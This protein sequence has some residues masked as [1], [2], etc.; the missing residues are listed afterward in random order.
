MEKKKYP[1]MGILSA[2]VKEGAQTIKMQGWC[3]LKY[4]GSKEKLD[5]DFLSIDVPVQKK[6]G[7]ISFGSRYGVPVGKRFRLNHFVLTFD[8][9]QAL[10]YDIQNKVELVYK[11]QYKGRILYRPTDLKKG[12]NRRSE[13]FIR[14]NSIIYFRQSSKNSLYLTT[15]EANIYDYPEGEERIDKAYRK[16]KGCR[17]D[18]IMMYEKNCSRYEESASVLYEKLIDAGYDNVYYVVNGD[19]KEIQGLDEKYKKNL[20]EKDS[21]DHLELFFASNTFISTETTDHALQLRSTNKKVIEKQNG[22]NLKYVFLQHGVMYMVS[23]NSDKRV[24]FRD[25]NLGLQRTVVSSELEAKHF[26]ELAGMPREKLYITGLAKF[27]TSYRNDDADKIIIMPTWRRWEMNQAKEDL[28]GTGYFR[29]IKKMYDAVPEKLKEKVIVLPH[30]LMAEKFAG[31]EDFGKNLVLG[32]SYDKILRSCDML[33]TDYSSVSYDAFYRGANIVFYWAEKEECMEQYG[34]GS[35]LMLNNENVFGEV[36]MN[37]EDIRHAIQIGYKN[38]QP[39]IYIERYRKIV[40][41][42]DGHNADRILECLIKD[43]II[44]PKDSETYEA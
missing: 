8:I 11:D 38:K 3:I 29:M 27:D 34:E 21:D 40:E 6:A 16:A 9:D 31:E 20:V 13:V 23:L 2:K 41:F 5:T 24:G 18:L 22:K 17:Q 33:I 26:I 30:P 19:N 12:K 43:K 4:I 28:Q 37:E 39:Q 1:R 35:Y 10:K 14:E 36:C 7:T 15:R 42:H 25:K 32:D 44:K